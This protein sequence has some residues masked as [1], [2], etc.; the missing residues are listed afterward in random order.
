MSVYE[1]HEAIKSENLELLSSQLDIVESEEI[2]Q[3]IGELGRIAL[4][5]AVMQNNIEIVE[6]L[7]NAGANV[8]A[9]DRQGVTPLHKARSITIASLLIDKGANINAP[10]HANFSPLHRVAEACAEN[11]EARKVVKLLIG[12]GADPNYRGDGGTTPLMSVVT[13][14]DD[15]ETVKLL[16][17]GG[18]LINT[19]NSKGATPLMQACKKEHTKVAY[20]LLNNGADPAMRRDDG[21]SALHL[22][23][24]GDY[25]DEEE[26]LSLAKALIKN[27]AKTSYEAQLESGTLTAYEIAVYYKRSEDFCSLLKREYGSANNG[28]KLENKEIKATLVYFGITAIVLFILLIIAKIIF[29]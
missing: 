4:N 11:T 23:A 15:V 3:Q 5:L 8:N 21:S 19:T 27:G 9:S 6:M 18:A 17:E 1:I 28:S 20:F 25:Y 13:W 14:N 10:G 26:R 29:G 2:D 24:S 22:L 7:I 16:L 12:R